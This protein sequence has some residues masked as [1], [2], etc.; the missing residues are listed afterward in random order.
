MSWNIDG[1]DDNNVTTR[2]KSV[3]KTILSEKPDV[4][5]LQEVVTKNLGVIKE[6]CTNYF[7]VLGTDRQLFPG[8]YF[9]VMLLRN[10]TTKYSN[11]SVQPFYSSI[12][13]RTLLQVNAK[14]KGIEI[15]LLT[16][17]L[18]S[19]KTWEQ[20]RTKQFRK[21]LD[22]AYEVPH[23]KAVILGGDFNLRDSELEKIGGLKNGLVDVWEQTGRRSE[24]QFTWDTKK[25]DNLSVSGRYKPRHR[26]DRLYY[27]SDCF[28]KAVYFELVGFDRVEACK[29]FPSDHW[30][31]MAH[32]NILP[33]VENKSLM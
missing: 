31:I 24:A 2:A 22:A 32:F 12:M 6:Y 10:D 9:T 29:R 33:H 26:F 4:V 19:T 15:C 14:V 17:H 7:V 16:S 23:S 30:G 25:N 27:R 18:E 28:I 3:C 21:I 20:E 5:F 8:E 13:S 11:H 1:L